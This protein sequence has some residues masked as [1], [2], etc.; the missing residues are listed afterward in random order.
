[1]KSKLAHL[2]NIVFYT[3]CTAPLLI[4]IILGFKL[5]AL[6]YSYSSPDFGS[7]PDWLSWITNLFIAF[8]TIVVAKNA[9][10][11]FSEKIHAEG[12]NRASILMDDIDNAYKSYNSLSWKVFLDVRRFDVSTQS[13]DPNR[14]HYQK[15][16]DSAESSLEEITALYAD[17]ANIKTSM[18]LLSRW[19]LTCN[20]EETFNSFINSVAESLG[21]MYGITH[22]ISYI[23]YPDDIISEQ[24]YRDRI[25]RHPRLKDE[26]DILYRHF[27]TTPLN[28]LFSISEKRE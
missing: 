20:Q 3:L 5:L 10:D 15:V 25:E 17:I 26:L 21:L 12:F 1:M 18:E 11:F 2:D 8:I 9:K 6:V 16:I 22:Y 4:I 27:A 28:K 19:S 24:E 7:W 23:N 14:V 13:D